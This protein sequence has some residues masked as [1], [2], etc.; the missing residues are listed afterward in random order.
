MAEV[1][2]AKKVAALFWKSMRLPVLEC[3]APSRGL[4]SKRYAPVIDMLYPQEIVS[5][6]NYL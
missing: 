2:L 5:Y 4:T 6:S 1:G 3:A